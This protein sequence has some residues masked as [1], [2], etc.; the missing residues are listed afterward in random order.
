[1]LG[2][3]TVR[4]MLSNPKPLLEKSVKQSNPRKRG[5][6]QWFSDNEDAIFLWDSYFT[7][8]ESLFVLDAKDKGNIGRFYNHCWYE[9]F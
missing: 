8:S 7:E 1:M 6:I 3:A 4:K 5:I 9:R 2:K